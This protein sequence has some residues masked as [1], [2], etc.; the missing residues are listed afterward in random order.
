[1][2][3]KAGKLFGH[4]LWTER[5]VTQGYPVSPM[6]FNILVDAVVRAVLL[7]VCGTQ[8]AHRGFGW[9][10]CEQIFFMRTMGG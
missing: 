1:M 7:E 2:V 4:L 3:P 10:T 5:G 9:V 6:I 8:E